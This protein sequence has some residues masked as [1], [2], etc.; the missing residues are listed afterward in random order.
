M[1]KS[2]L[3][4]LLT[5]SALLIGCNGGDIEKTLNDKPEIITELIKKHPAKF[6]MAFQEAAKNAQKEMAQ[7]REEEEAKKLEKTYDSPLVPNLR[8]DESYRGT[9]GAPITLIEYSDFE[10]PFCTRGFRTVQEL[11]TKYKGKV[12]FVY[13]HLPLSF[14]KNARNASLYY[15]AIRLQD[16]KKAFAFHDA[17]FANQGKLKSGE[18]FLKAIAKKVGANMS[19]LAKDKDSKK[20]LARIEED[21]K[22]A[23]KFGMQ[24]TPGFL[25]NGIPVKGA[26]PLSHFDKII[27]ELKKRGKLKL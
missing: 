22:E 6:I 24:G 5:L 21:L 15:E 26:Y 9:K 19:Q 11:M 23:A 4:I 25:L 27:A 1:K 7:V 13:K 2:L 10:C 16:E 3:F 18:G 14:H 20:V 12:A 8:A 17:I